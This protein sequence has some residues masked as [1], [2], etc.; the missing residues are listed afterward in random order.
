VELV[1]L[2]QDMDAPVVA[3]M[4]RM[5]TFK[6]MLIP[7]R[8]STLEASLEFANIFRTPVETKSHSDLFE[9]RPI[10]RREA[11]A[12]AVK[13]KAEV[14]ARRIACGEHKNFLRACLNVIA[15]RTQRLLELSARRR[16]SSARHFE[17]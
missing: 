12:A 3:A 9:P 8:S 10:F 5:F 16:L 1:S 7:V 6:F 4:Q 14:R 2:G 13:V 17:Y 15:R 11:A